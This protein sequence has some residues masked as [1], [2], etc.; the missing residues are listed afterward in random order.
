MSPNF[1]V[2]ALIFSPYTPEI[3][4][5]ILHPSLHSL[6]H[7]SLGKHRPAWSLAR[8]PNAPFKIVSES[9]K[10]RH[11]MASICVGGGA[12]VRGRNND[13]GASAGANV[14]ERV[15]CNSE[16]AASEVFLSAYRK[17]KGYGRLS[18]ASIFSALWVMTHGSLSALP[19]GPLLY[20]LIFCI[21]VSISPFQLLHALSSQYISIIMCAVGLS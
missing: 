5:F 7:C 1:K 3:H 15:K 12:W 18:M 11:R 2:T 6:I 9:G 19:D 14:P 8:S 16:K 20:L 10:T 4:R 17:Q 21:C 13:L